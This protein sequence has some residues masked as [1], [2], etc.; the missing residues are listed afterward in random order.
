MTSSN[1]TQFQF[2]HAQQETI[3]EIFDERMELPVSIEV[4]AR[5]DDTIVRTDKPA[6][7]HCQDTLRLARMLASLHP[8]LT[9]TWYDIDKFEKRATEAGIERAPL[10]ILRGRNG[11]EMRILG[12]WTGALF[13]AI[14]D[15][16][17][18][19]SREES[20]Y[21]EASRAII[22][23]L[24]RDI[25]L[26]VYGAIYDQ[27]SAQMLRMTGALAAQSRHFRVQFTELVGAQDIALQKEIADIPVMVLD[28]TRYLGVWDE[29]SLMQQLEHLI[30]GRPVI[31]TP[32]QT[33][34][35]PYYSE[36]D[37]EHMATQQAAEAAATSNEPPRTAS[38]LYLPS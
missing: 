13:P 31:V 37:I 24:D 35:V 30:A 33:G 4:W 25:D 19:L 15:I 6:C 2:D 22:D 27:L 5:K 8:G 21:S 16:I 17:T 23:S 12:F 29:Q 20:P 14:V 11:R 28:N 3:G 32:P 1:Q 10:T 7:P 36:A 26:Q 38:G 18:Y 9:V 34:T